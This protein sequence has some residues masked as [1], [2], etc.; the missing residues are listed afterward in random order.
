MSRREA[1]EILKPGLTKAIRDWMDSVCEDDAWE[2]LDAYT[3]DD[4][5]TYMSDAALAAWKASVNAQEFAARQ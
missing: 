1:F 2:A 4:L 3:S 5:A